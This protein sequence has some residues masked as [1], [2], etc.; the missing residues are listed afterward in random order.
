MIEEKET[1]LSITGKLRELYEMSDDPEIDMQAWQ[2]TFEAV[3]GERDDK[4]NGYAAVIAK[5][6]ADGKAIKEQET[7]L[8]E[9]RKAI[10]H[11]IERMMA[12][13]SYSMSTTNE[14]SIKTTYWTFAMRKN[15]QSVVIDNASLVPK[16]YLK[17]AEPTIDKKALR[18]DLINGEKLDGVA[19]LEQTERLD[20][21]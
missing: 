5:L 6:K 19:H 3:T 17:Y 9:R 18:D 4:L 15:P 20:I 8:Y 10:E 14:R 13:I 2:D 21:R 7:R 16:Q 11:S 1:L 12:N